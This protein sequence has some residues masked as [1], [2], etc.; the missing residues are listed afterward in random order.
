MI[1]LPAKIY[2]ASAPVDM[3]L[4]FDRLAGI[5]RRE[6]GADPRDETVVVF[7]NKRCTL[8]KLFWFDGSGYCVLY[9]RI[10]KGTFRFPLVAP[11]GAARIEVSKRE[12]KLMLRGV[13]RVALRRAR[14]RFRR[15]AA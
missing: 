12:L 9:K 2:V 15:P 6:L 4:S 7:H 11:A 3:R 13:D 1:G 5:V 8:L 14:A 10:D